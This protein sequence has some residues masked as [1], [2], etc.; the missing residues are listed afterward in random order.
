MAAHDRGGPAARLEAKSIGL[1]F[2]D[3]LYTFC[4]LYISARC[5]SAGMARKDGK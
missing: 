5:V 4:I 2:S 1:N 3:Y